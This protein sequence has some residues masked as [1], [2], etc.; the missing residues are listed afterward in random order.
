MK[1]CRTHSKSDFIMLKT[2]NRT[3]SLLLRSPF[4]IRNYKYH[5][6]DFKKFAYIKTDTNG[7]TSW[8]CFFGIIGGWTRR[9]RASQ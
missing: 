1:I 5:N 7:V 6:G 4:K 9:S 8:N 2:S 3:F